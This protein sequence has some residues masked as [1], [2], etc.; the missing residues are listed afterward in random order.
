MQQLRLSFQDHRIFSILG[1][2]QAKGDMEVVL[3]VADLLARGLTENQDVLAIEDE[4]RHRPD[5]GDR[6]AARSR[7]RECDS[8]AGARQHV[9]ALDWSDQAWN[10]PSLL[11]V[12]FRSRK[13]GTFTS[14]MASLP[15]RV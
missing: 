1:L 15:L 11:L 3:H 14:G 2:I 4:K 5:G 7:A 12:V 8:C 6:L 10:N 13:T 9:Y